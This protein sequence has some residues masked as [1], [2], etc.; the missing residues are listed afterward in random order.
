LCRADSGDPNEEYYIPAA[1]AKNNPAQR[2]AG[3]SIVITAQ[4]LK[5]VFDPV[6][7]EVV[8][9]VKRQI[10]NVKGEKSDVA[11]VLLVGGFGQSRYLKKRIEEE[12]HP[13]SLLCPP[14]GWSAIARGACIKGI[15][16]RSSA[17]EWRVNTRKATEHLGIEIQKDFLT[18][19]HDTSRRYVS[20]SV[21]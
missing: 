21:F 10:S 11:A 3:G 17:P 2:I 20:H 5:A 6:I 16:T 15:A 4:D 19:I 8:A 9:L 18:G 7:D 13:I 12:I 1:G 14:N